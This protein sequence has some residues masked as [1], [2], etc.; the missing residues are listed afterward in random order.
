VNRNIAPSAGEHDQH[1]APLTNEQ[2][3]MMRRMRDCPYPTSYTTVVRLE[4]T[5]RLRP[6]VLAAAL[7]ALAVR[8]HALRSRFVSGPD[9]RARQIVDAP[10]PVRLERADVSGAPPAQRAEA[11]R[12]LVDRL[13]GE[14]FDLAAGHLLRAALLRTE[15]HTWQLYLAYHHIA[16]DGWA[17]RVL[18]EDLAA[19]YTACL[20][21]G[22]AAGATPVP[23][24]AV[25]SADCARS[26]RTAE[27][28]ARAAGNIRY[29][30]SVLAGQTQVINW[31]GVSPRPQDFI[32]EGAVEPVRIGGDVHRALRRTAAQ[33]GASSFVTVAAAL[34]VFLSRLSGQRDLIVSVPFF[35][36]SEADARAVTCLSGP[37]LL[38]CEVREEETFATLVERTADRFFDGIEHAALPVTELLDTLVRE[39]GWTTTRTPCAAIAMQ[40]FG[41]DE[42]AQLP[43]VGARLH[44]ESVHVALTD[45]VL[46]LTESDDGIDGFALYRRALFD[47]ATVHRWMREFTELTAALARRPDLPLEQAVP[48]PAR[49]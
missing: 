27:A 17:L 23:A 1:A 41:F 16:V 44:F 15:E 13:Q 5:G 43:G 28:R 19:L 14:P 40:S 47:S 48:A 12:L 18:L 36:R 42:V 33:C 2:R 10:R 45:L 26:Q 30:R 4:L 9:G 3:L 22:G 38:L 35:N 46:N 32:G 6:E 29:W 25:Q 24:A 11:A 39:D 49:T 8:H 34:A 31:P 21:E 37:V 7:D 20:E